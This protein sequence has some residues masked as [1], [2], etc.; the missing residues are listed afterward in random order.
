MLMMKECTLCYVVRDGKVLRAEIKS[1]FSRGKINAPGG[2]IEEGETPEQAAIR[3]TEEEIGITPKNLV[4]LG[5]KEC[6]NGS[7]SLKIHIF[8]AD[9]FSGEERETEE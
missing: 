9:D 3:E 2:K 1:G 5:F 6:L 8:V 4:K 7:K